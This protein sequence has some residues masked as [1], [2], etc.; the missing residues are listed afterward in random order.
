MSKLVKPQV[1]RAKALQHDL[2]ATSGDS[3]VEWIEADNLV[4]DMTY[5][6]TQ[7]RGKV[8]RIAT[9]FDPDAFGVL[10]VSRR[11]DGTEVLID[12]G[13]RVAAIRDLGW[14]DQKLPAVVHTGLS[15]EEEAKIFTLTNRDRTKPTPRDMFRADVASKQPEALEI[16]AVFDKHGLELTN[17]TVRSRLWPCRP[18]GPRKRPRICKRRIHFLT[19]LTRL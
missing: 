18:P 8:Y 10:I 7:E 14:E 9:N 3:D 19:R 4:V 2:E 15:L 12:G 1:Q 16:Q 5:Q 17:R 13:H 6:R 11:K